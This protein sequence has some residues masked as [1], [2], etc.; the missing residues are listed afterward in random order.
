MFSRCIILSHP[1]R[2]HSPAPNWKAALEHP[3]HTA[4]VQE[5]S[6]P[7]AR[8]SRHSQG[9]RL[10][11]TAALHGSTAG[12][13]RTA[14]RAR[15]G[16]KGGME[17]RAQPQPLPSIVFCHLTRP[18]E[19][20]GLCHLCPGCLCSAGVS[21]VPGDTRLC[22]GASRDF[23]ECLCREKPFPGEEPLHP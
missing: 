3:S 1:A 7:P 2:Y 5:L 23:A 21:Q 16:G 11:C 15:Q 12:W 6:S 8:R 10:A 4:P 9:C 19:F 22:G 17:S 14:L 20:T 18:V 13:S